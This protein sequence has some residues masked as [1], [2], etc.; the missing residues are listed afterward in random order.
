MSRE[1]ARCRARRPGP[2]RCAAGRRSSGSRPGSSDPIPVCGADCRRPPGSAPRGAVPLIGLV[3]TVRVRSI[4]QESL[5]RGAGDLEV[6]EAQICRVRRRIAA[7]QRAVH[8]ETAGVGEDL[9]AV[10]EIH[11]VGLPGAQLGVDSGD[12]GEVA[13]ASTGEPGDNRGLVGGQG[14]RLRLRPIRQCGNDGRGSRPASAG[15]ARRRPRR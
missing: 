1:H 8:I 14:E 5:G 3:S 4:V 7:A 9:G 15:S 12:V 6:V 10:G 2:G 13:V 11:L